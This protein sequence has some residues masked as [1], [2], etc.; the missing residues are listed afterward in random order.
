[1]AQSITFLG[2]AETVTGSRHLLEINGKRVLVDC[3]M[4]QGSSELRERNWQPFPVPPGTIDAVVIT[5]AHMDH[6]GWLPRF[7]REGYRGPFYATKATI[8]LSKISLPDS[9]RIQEEDARHHNKHQTSRH[10]PAL[11]LYNEDDA[12][13]CL[14]Q[15]QPVGYGELHPLPGGAQWRYLP[16]GHILGSAFAEIFFDNGE[17]ILMSGDLGRFNTPI[18]KDPTT[19]EFAET[20]VV[21]STYGDRLHSHEDPLG[22]IEEVVKAAWQSGGAV[23]TPS[24]AIGRTQELLYYMSELQAAN[25]IPRIPIYIDSPMATST[26]HIY[27]EALDEHDTEMKLALHNHENPLEPAGVQFVRDAE[28]SKAL[29]S[30]KG[31]MM[32]I[33]GSGMANGGRVVHHL[34]HRLPD[35]KTIVLFTGYQ[36]EGTLGRKLLEGADTV[37]IYGEEI[38]VRARID[39]AN[40][41][42]AHADQGE[43]IRWLKG[44][45][46]PPRK[47]YIVHGEPPAQA[48]LQAKIKEEL[49]WATVIPKW[50]ERFE[51]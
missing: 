29:N 8:A 20:L 50:K 17:R 39:K 46:T 36:A 42:S 21:E 15:F 22:K 3:G 44:F 47:T 16:A 51:L 35:P 7:V 28:Q 18:I 19:M 25:R 48:A 24:F 13:A 33:S 14:K 1:M 32:I 45:K 9:G 27:E 38:P 49:G 4:F 6:I 23:V 2:A 30:T 11:P 41:L 34:M 26:T 40:A 31:P 10:E 12:Y 43:I 37:R 5:H